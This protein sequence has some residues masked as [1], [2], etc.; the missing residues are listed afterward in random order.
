MVLWLHLLPLMPFARLHRARITTTNQS[1]RRICWRLLL[2]LQAAPLPRACA[3]LEQTQWRTCNQLLNNQAMRKQQLT[4]KIQVNR[5]KPM[6]KSKLK[7]RIRQSD[8]AGRG[9]GDELDHTGVRGKRPGG[10]VQIFRLSQLVSKILPTAA[11][12]IHLTGQSLSNVPWIFVFP[13][14]VLT[15]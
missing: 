4:G 1:R 6:M 13:V 15:D 10:L 7:K 2:M 5:R 14:Q 12:K 3:N 9:F 8:A 11:L